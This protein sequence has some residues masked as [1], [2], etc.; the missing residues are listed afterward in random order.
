MIWVFEV[1]GC[2]MTKFNVPEENVKDEVKE[3]DLQIPVFTMLTVRFSMNRSSFLQRHRP[4]PVWPAAVWGRPAAALPGLQEHE[5]GRGRPR[6]PAGVSRRRSGGPAAPGRGLCAV[7]AQCCRG[8]QG[9]VN[10][11]VSS[12]S[13]WDGWRF[14]RRVACCYRYRRVDFLYLNAGIMPNPTVDI[15]AFFKG[16]FSR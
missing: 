9:Q 10:E 15:R 14:W 5:A 2:D 7:G 6:C 4:G 3:D 16:L 8:T 12:M 13:Y 1:N 11:T